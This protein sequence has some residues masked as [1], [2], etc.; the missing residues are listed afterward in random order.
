MRPRF[1]L[2]LETRLGF[3]IVRTVPSEQKELAI[4]V[5]E[6]SNNNF[7]LIAAAVDGR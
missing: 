5:V 1:S 3:T 2:D 7:A 6:G 4:A